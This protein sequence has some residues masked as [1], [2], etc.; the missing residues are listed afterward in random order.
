MTPAE[1]ER[2][3]LLSM[4][5]QSERDHL[6][7]VRYVREIDELMSQKEKRLA[8]QAAPKR[9]VLPKKSDFSGG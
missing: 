5:I 4:L 3:N 6:T 8:E 9:P 2:M 7:Y 1:R